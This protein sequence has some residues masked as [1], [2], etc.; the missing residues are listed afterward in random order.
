MF[1]AVTMKSARRGLSAMVAIAALAAVGC[2]GGGGGGSNAGGNGGGGGDYGNGGNNGGPYGGNDGGS[3]LSLASK[4]ELGNYLVSSEGRTL[5]YFAL[6]VPAGAGQAPVSQCTADCLQ[7]WP[8]FHVDTPAV[9]AGLK[10][11]DF[12]EFVR[13][14]GTKQTTF[15]G[16]PLYFFA[17][18]TAAE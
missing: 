17:G 13:P 9:G 7:F 12:G 5:Y 10:T 18:D 15:K 3:T 4:P 16:W 2:G 11:S 14:E 1:D 6:D 8:I